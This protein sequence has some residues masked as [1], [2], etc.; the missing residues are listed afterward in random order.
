[1][2]E[3]KRSP[4]K[5]WWMEDNTTWR[6]Q[7]SASP[8][9]QDSGFSDTEIAP[10]QKNLLLRDI[11][12]DASNDSSKTKNSNEQYKEKSLTD[13]NLPF[14]INPTDK[15]NRS[16]L[17]SKNENCISPKSTTVPQKSLYQ[18]QRTR[19]NLFKTDLTKAATVQNNN[20]YAK[21][22]NGTK[23]QPQISSKVTFNASNVSLQESIS[24]DCNAQLRLNRSA[25]AVLGVLKENDERVEKEDEQISDCDSE[26]ENFFR[27]AAAESPK[28]TSTPKAERAGMRQ[29]KRKA[30]LNLHQARIQ[31]ER[32]VLRVS[33]EFS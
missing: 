33:N 26:I 5:V 21:G 23:S 17:Q 6:L 4:S 19:K 30:A 24:T 8:G 2:S 11:S 32:Y 13:K 12:K 1:M 20:Q 29:C 28:H 31:R 18:K 22:D 9:S 14:Q 10:A 7:S 15:L 16:L 3:F 27:E 25:P